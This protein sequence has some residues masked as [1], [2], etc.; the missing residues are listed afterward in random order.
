M[1]I[2]NMRLEIKFTM[3]FIVTKIIIITAKNSE[4]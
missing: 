4:Q 3:E 1:R 2:R